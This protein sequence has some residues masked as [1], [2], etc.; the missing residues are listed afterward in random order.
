MVVQSVSITL[1][2]FPAII[3]PVSCRCTAVFAIFPI[4]SYYDEP[5][6]TV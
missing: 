3:T 4:L 6:W 1:V 2:R 5:G